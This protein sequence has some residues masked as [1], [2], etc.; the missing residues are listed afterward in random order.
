M[1]SPLLR[2]ASHQRTSYTL[3]RGTRGSNS[4][5][6]VSAFQAECRR[7]ESGLP[8]PEKPITTG[9]TATH[10]EGPFVVWKECGH[11]VAMLAVCRPRGALAEPYVASNGAE[12]VHLRGRSFLV[13]IAALQNCCSDRCCRIAAGVGGAAPL[14]S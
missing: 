10:C 7:F 11:F 3:I 9:K 5:G 6:R 13:R 8:L 2:V 1:A 4:V 12:D 14:R